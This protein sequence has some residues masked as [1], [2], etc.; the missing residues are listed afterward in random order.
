MASHGRLHSENALKRQRNSP[1]GVIL[2]TELNKNW[3]TSAVAAGGGLESK[4]HRP[5][6]PFYHLS[7]GTDEYS[8]PPW[9]SGFIYGPPEDRD[10]YGLLPL[11]KIDDKIGV[12]DG[13]AGPEINV[14]GRHH[15]GGDDL[16]G[17][18]NFLYTDGHVER[19][20][21]LQTMK[22]REWGSRY[23]SL[24]GK[25]EVLWGD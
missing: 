22:L 1:R 8:A 16:G 4:S 13:S 19:K 5:V 25:N 2:A 15:P 18:A 20:T 24:S 9:A 6:N 12:I 7:T 21:I 3:I 11:D 17:T 14:V 10:T 23:Y